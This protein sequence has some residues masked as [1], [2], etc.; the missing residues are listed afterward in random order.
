MQ[1]QTPGQ[2]D[3]EL[4]A[5]L[6][7]LAAFPN[8]LRQRL[9]GLGDAALRYKPTPS[10]WS[11]VEIVGHYGDIEAQWAGRIR[12]VLAA[13]QPTFPG[14]NPDATVE[15]QRYQEKQ[16]PAL[17]AAFA[18]R[19]GELVEFARGLRPAQV[20]RS[21]I[22]PVRGPI[23][24]AGALIILANHDQMHLRQIEA[25]LEQHAAGGGR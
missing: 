10:E 11:V 12:Q 25:N 21:G 20:E 16:L 24:V 8:E 6:D 23:T 2:F 13:E 15:Q 7:R 19:R 17:L 3:P 9:Q 5:A 14:F 18:E 1:S 4:R 22:H